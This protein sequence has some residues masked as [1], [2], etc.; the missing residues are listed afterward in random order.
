MS[1]LE[2]ARKYK[3]E[4]IGKASATATF[5][6]LAST[7]L[8]KLTQGFVGKILYALLTLFF[9]G[10]ASV[11][12]VVLNI[13]IAKVETLLEQKDFDGSFDEAFKIINAKGG[14]LTQ[15][16]IAEIDSKVIDAFRKFAVFG[17]LRDH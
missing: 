8:A 16:E 13:G 17:K 7:P 6:A 15:Q 9:S 3:F 14:K 10:L 1:A 2:P 12:L 11:G 4:G 5:V